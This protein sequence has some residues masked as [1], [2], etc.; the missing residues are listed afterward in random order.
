M[1]PFSARGFV[2]NMRAQYEQ[3]GQEQ[4]DGE[5]LVLLPVEIGLEGEGL[6]AGVHRFAVHA[7]VLYA[8]GLTVDV[9]QGQRVSGR[10]GLYTLT[11]TA[12]SPNHIALDSRLTEV[13]AFSVDI[14]CEARLEI[15]RIA[16]S[17]QVFS[18]CLKFGATLRT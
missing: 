12:V 15:A 13:L 7:G 4:A 11:D 16:G 10:R 8:A 9:C 18:A 5:V 2:E 14:S 17:I 3:Q 1:Q 6:N